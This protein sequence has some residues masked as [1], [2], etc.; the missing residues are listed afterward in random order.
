MEFPRLLVVGWIVSKS[1]DTLQDGM[2]R[3]SFKSFPK[4]RKC[5]KMENGN[6]ICRF[7][8]YPSAAVE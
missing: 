4:Q 7:L 5:V 8:Q 2:R 3:L 6:V 1:R